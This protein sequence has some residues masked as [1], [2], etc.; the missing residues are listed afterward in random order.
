MRCCIDFPKYV[1]PMVFMYRHV[2]FERRPVSFLH[3][4]GRQ[5]PMIPIPLIDP[6]NCLH[7]FDGMH[8]P[9]TAHPRA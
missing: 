1:S 5:R 6:L 7:P 4:L 2:P 3:Q 9:L 8:R